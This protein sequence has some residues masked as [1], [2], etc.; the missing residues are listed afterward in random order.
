MAASQYRC[1]GR[2]HCGSVWALD[3]SHGTFVIKRE[4]GG[5]GRSVLNDQIMH[6]RVLGGGGSGVPVRIA[7]SYEVIEPSDPWWQTTSGLACFPSN[8][9]PCRAYKMERIPAM[10]LDARQTLINN[11]CPEGLQD[12]V[13]TNRGD[14]D[15]LIRLYLGRRRIN[16]QT[17]FQRFSLRNYPLHVDQMEELGVDTHNIA[18]TL[19]DAL[20]HCHWRAHV[21]ANDVEFVMASESREQTDTGLVNASFKAFGSEYVIWL[22]DFDCCRHMAQ[23][24]DGIAQAVQSFY[25]NDPYY[26]R[27]FAHGYTD[28][29]AALWETFRTR[30]LN[31]SHEILK[32]QGSQH[33]ATMF[34]DKVEEEGR[35][36]RLAALTSEAT[37]VEFTPKG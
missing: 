22:L 14:E 37:P 3:D 20:A 35:R 29:D 7:L 36:R 24:E 15:C 21:D 9:E 32:G 13:R 2:G 4:D 17:K 12:F 33:L 8:F 23:N 11:Y 30:F 6:R 16:R 19:A 28:E 27:P 5:P 1:I 25:R 31:T 10:L 18:A 34:I 26:P